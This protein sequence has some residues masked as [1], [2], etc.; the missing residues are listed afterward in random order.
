MP[1]RTPNIGI[2]KYEIDTLLTWRRSHENPPLRHAPNPGSTT[3][4]PRK[5][6]FEA[7][8]K[9]LGDLP[10]SGSTRSP[11]ATPPSTEHIFT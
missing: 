1:G 6:C 9:R 2:H 11:P 8:T 7:L 4:P 10:E 5:R 3:V